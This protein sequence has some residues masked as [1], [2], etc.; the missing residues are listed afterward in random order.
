MGVSWFSSIIVYHKK[1]SRR[2]AFSFQKGLLKFLFWNLW[3]YLGIW[4]VIVA[5]KPGSCKT[6]RESPTWSY[7]LTQLL[8]DAKFQ[9][10]LFYCWSHHD[11]SRNL[12]LGASDHQKVKLII[13]WIVPYIMKQLEHNNPW[14]PDNFTGILRIQKS[15]EEL[16]A[17]GFNN[18]LCPWGR[19]ADCQYEGL[20][21]KFTAMVGGRPNI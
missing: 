16:E 13:K 21:P 6:E 10:C 19:R 12:G 14:L 4:K 8:R 2:I 3:I 5:G 18:H 20:N 11:G 15:M 7:W 1:W 17:A 9:I